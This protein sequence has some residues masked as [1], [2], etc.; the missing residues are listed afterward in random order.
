[1]LALARA[2]AETV[3]LIPVRTILTK[4]F[5]TDFPKE[6]K[7]IRVT[8]KF[9]FP[10]A[11]FPKEQAATT[12]VAQV[13]SYVH[14]LT[15]N[16]KGCHKRKFFAIAILRGLCSVLLCGQV[17]KRKTIAPIRVLLYL[18]DPRRVFGLVSSRFISAI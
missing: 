15:F 14:N 6:S 7:T 8:V 16:G 13:I 18:V 11:G 10:P 2:A 1:M 4:F 12:A 5:K 17:Q 9:H 3:A